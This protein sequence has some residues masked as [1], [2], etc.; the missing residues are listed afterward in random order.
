MF[1]T[2]RIDGMH[3]AVQQW[4]LRFAE[5]QK[6]IQTL[7]ALHL[8]SLH[9]HNAQVT[10]I[11]IQLPK[12]HEWHSCLSRTKSGVTYA[13]NLPSEEIY[14]VPIKNGVDGIVY[15]SIPL[16]Y[17]GF[18]IKNY[19]LRFENGKVVETGAEEGAD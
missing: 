5:M 6:Q 4:Q 12:D 7:N 9:Y 11:S 18:V 10:D 8:Q 1:K 15:G 16:V 19:Y 14:T 3:D 17:Q 13:M 2:L